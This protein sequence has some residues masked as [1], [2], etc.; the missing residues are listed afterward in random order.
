MDL[1]NELIRQLL[2]I[3]NA[4]FDYVS[5]RMPSRRLHEAE[6]VGL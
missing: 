4:D 5:D 3:V 6:L 1:R 2:V